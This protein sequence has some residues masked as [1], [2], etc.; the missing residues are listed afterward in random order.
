M[1]ENRVRVIR[2]I[3]GGAFG[4]K[5]DV[6]VEVHI[7]LLARA[8]GRPVRLVL[9]REESFLFA[10]EATCHRDLDAVGSHEGG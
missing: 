3:T 10:D 4:G 7:G 1:K 6:T 2:A 5:D 9:D 8:T